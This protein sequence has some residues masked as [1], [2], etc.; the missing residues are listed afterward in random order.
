MVRAAA[1]VV[2][3][4]ALVSRADDDRVRAWLDAGDFARADS[5]ARVLVDA[6]PRGSVE[7]TEAELLRVET[8]RRSGSLPLDTIVARAESL[9]AVQTALLD[10]DDPRVAE[11]H[12][13]LANTHVR[14]GDQARAAVAFRQAYELRRSSL[15]DDASLTIRS[16]LGL[17]NALQWTGETDAARALFDRQIALL[18]AAPTGRENRLVFA[19]NGL[20]YLHKRAGER[21]AAIEAFRR[22][23]ALA[24]E[25][26]PARHLTRAL[27]ERNLGV[28]L[29]DDRP[30]AAVEHLRRAL[31]VRRQLLPP[32]DVL[33]GSVAL[34]LA[35]VE[36]RLG[37]SGEAA[38]HFERALTA[39]RDPDARRAAFVDWANAAIDAGDFDGA[40][41]AI[42]G[43]RDAGASSSTVLAL[44]ANRANEMGDVDVAIDLYDRALHR[45]AREEGRGGADF[46]RL[47]HNRAE[48][49][50]RGGRIGAALASR[51]D[52]VE[53][54]ERVLGADDPDLA[55]GRMNL[56]G[57]LLE[58]G[59]AAEALPLLD[60]VEP[61]LTARLT[62]DHPALANLLLLRARALAATGDSAAA[63]DAAENAVLRRRRAYGEEHIEVAWARDAAA[64]HELAAG[65]LD[66]AAVHARAA[67]RIAREHLRDAVLTDRKS[68]V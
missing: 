49:L 6:A 43:A 59:A 30:E 8:A 61:V 21:E 34:S 32:G 56:A 46:A 65:V 45:R 2:L 31:D 42:D 54:Q 66:R 62:P 14:R 17:A 37:R 4:L 15:G 26:L 16:A 7:W 23:V 24:R 48:M 55:L 40:A 1:S 44:R 36:A 52:A 35:R 39:L 19:L 50:A 53:I 29:A 51:R 27:V 63:V 20:G 3:I 12:H 60:A 64:R 13:Q 58:A 67:D 41:R 33:I 18:E 5:L 57:S 38:A 25:H 10:R 11:A 22:A 47:L 68:V 28:E 9:I